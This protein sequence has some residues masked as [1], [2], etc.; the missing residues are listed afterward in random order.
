MDPRVLTPGSPGERFEPKGFELWRSADGKTWKQVVQPGL[1]NHANYTA[2]TRASGGRL[3]L[4]VVNYRQGDSL[5]TSSNGRAWTVVWREGQGHR[6]GE[7]GGWFEF[8]G[9]VFIQTNDLARGID[10]WRSR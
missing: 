10:V 2:Y 6:Y 1:G 4:F 7:G 5:W 3:G 8:G 9:H